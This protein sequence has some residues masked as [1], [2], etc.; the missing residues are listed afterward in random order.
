MGNERGPSGQ[1][2]CR[3]C[4][5]SRIFPKEVEAADKCRWTEE[6]NRTAATWSELKVLLA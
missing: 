4:L 2:R 1:Q 6:S 3:D 5:L